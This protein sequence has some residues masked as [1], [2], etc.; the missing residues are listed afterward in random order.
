[1]PSPSAVTS[2][3]RTAEGKEEAPPLL[4][5]AV[6]D[7]RRRAAVYDFL[8]ARLSSLEASTEYDGRGAFIAVVQKE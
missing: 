1:M 4:A 8:C 2:K 6:P 7:K 5:L 3:T